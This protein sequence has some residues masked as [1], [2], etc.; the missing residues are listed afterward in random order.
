MDHEVKNHYRI[1]VV[2]PGFFFVGNFTSL[3]VCITTC[4]LS[5]AH[6][7]PPFLVVTS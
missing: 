3:F 1:T 4:V 6:N 7:T 5:E 2:D